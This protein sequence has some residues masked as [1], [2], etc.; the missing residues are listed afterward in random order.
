MGISKIENIELS[1]EELERYSRHIVIPE[2]GI[3]GQKKLK[4]AKVLVIGAGGLGSPVLTYLAAAGIGK[5]GIVDFDVVSRTNLQRQILFSTNDIGKQKAEIAKQKLNALNP[6]VEIEIYSVKLDRNNALGILKPY[7]VI[8]DGSDNFA[9]RYLVNDACVMLGKPF[10]YGSILQF[11]GQVSFFDST[12]GA[13]YRCL[14]P[15][16]PE[17][18]EVPSCDQAGVLGVL[19]G[20]I[21]SIQA[22]EVL[23]FILGKGELL[24]GRLLI[25]DALKM[26]FHE[27][28]FEKNPDCPVCSAN[29]GSVEL[30]DYDE[31]CNSA[32]NEESLSH[33]MTVEELKAKI[34]KGENVYIIDVRE[35]FERDIASIGGVL[36]PLNSLPDKI[37]EIEAS[38]DDEIVIYCHSGRRSDA[39]AEFLRT[40]AGFKNV[41]NLLGGITA[42]SERIDSSISKY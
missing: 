32:A 10:V 22:N 19:P 18:G 21:G 14:Y 9:T 29:P 2:V 40:R 38:K 16:P 35:P 8:V 13:C 31:F 15:N 42:W 28:E 27:L 26:K 30:I 34:D 5:I 17:P 39:A 23:K 1:K 7:D 41:K 36:I 25:L 12:K 6:N 37:E 33:D 20:I 24:T 11:A 4:N 3:E